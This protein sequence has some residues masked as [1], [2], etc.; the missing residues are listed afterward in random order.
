MTIRF[1][2]SVKT[3]A[4]STQIIKIVGFK[5]WSNFQSTPIIREYAGREYALY[6]LTNQCM[7]SILQP[8]QKYV[9]D[10]C[11]EPG[12]L[13]TELAIWRNAPVSTGTTTPYPISYFVQSPTH[14]YVYCYKDNITITNIT[15]ECP[16]DVFKVPV[17]NSF[18]IASNNVK[19]KASKRTLITK[20]IQMPFF[21]TIHPFHFNSSDTS[22]E[23]L[24]KIIDDLK[25]SNQNLN[26]TS[27]IYETYE[28]VKNPAKWRH[29]IIAFI[30]IV[31]FLMFKYVFP[32]FKKRTTSMNPSYSTPTVIPLKNRQP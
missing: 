4:P 12:Y 6:N 13:D 5:H 16:L 9:Y 26:T 23:S 29:D 2:F 17:E 18:N 28:S 1:H 3:P 19:Y 31:A 22:P 15:L 20:N 27:P 32:M 10:E 21:D 7:K 24:L 25:L 11:I 14:N 8:Q 30:L